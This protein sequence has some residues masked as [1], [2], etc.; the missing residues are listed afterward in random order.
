MAPAASDFRIEAVDPD[1]HGATFLG[2]YERSPEDATPHPQAVL[3][4]GEGS[5]WLAY[6]G[7]R[8]V[9]GIL[10]RE[11]RSSDGELRG[12]LENVIVDRDWR[13]R[14]LGRLLLEHAEAHFR[15]RGLFGMQSG[16]NPAN[17]IS[18][19][20]FERL[21]FRTVH[22]YTRTRNGVEEPRIQMWKDF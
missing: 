6:H 17:P 7:A 11:Q 16:G 12:F 22:R 14:G 13:G 5:L 18:I 9:G 3:D 21:G 1:V 19:P 10:T 2:F 4:E 15:E 8:A 20:L